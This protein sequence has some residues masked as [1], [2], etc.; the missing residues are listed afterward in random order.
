[1][2][3][4]L[5]PMLIAG[6]ALGFVTVLPASAQDTTA[7][8]RYVLEKTDDGLVRLDTLT[9]ELSVCEE[10]S[11]QV[12]CKLPADE[13]RAV[14]E[15]IADLE[16]RIAALEARVEALE[17]GRNG[18]GGSNA[19]PSDEELDEAFNMMEKFIYRFFDVFKDLDKRKDTPAE[20]G[21]G[22]M[23]RKT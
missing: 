11:G 18:S 6:C 4:T 19:L 23:P 17:A 21:E 1:M 13:R 22:D 5:G 9:G 14:N 20:P 10:R 16:G 3:K 15:H 2:N 12:I 8:G 7:S